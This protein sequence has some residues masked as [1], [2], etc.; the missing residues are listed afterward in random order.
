MWAHGGGALRR[1]GVAADLAVG[2]H[3]VGAVVGV[4]VRQRAV[5]GVGGGEQ[6]VEVVVGV[7]PAVGRPVGAGHAGNAAGGGARVSDVLQRRRA[8]QRDH[9]VQPAA[10]VVVGVVGGDAVGLSR[11]RDLAAGVVGERVDVAGNGFQA[12]GFVVGP[13]GGGPILR[14]KQYD[15]SQFLPTIA[16]QNFSTLPMASAL[17]IT[18]PSEV[19]I[20]VPPDAAIV[21]IRYSLFDQKL[22]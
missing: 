2:Q 22:P 12:A 5:T 1:V 6:A 10:R 7:G 18:M 19:S 9:P 20:S 11:R 4:R 13:G 16:E 21:C 17:V 8:L 15:A 3:V 14:R